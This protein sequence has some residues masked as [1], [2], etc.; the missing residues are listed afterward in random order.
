MIKLI[1]DK[2]NPLDVIALVEAKPKNSKTEWNPAW[3]KFNN[4]NI[5]SVNMNPNDCGRGILIFVIKII[6]YCIRQNPNELQEMMICDIAIDRKF[7]RLAV[8]YGSPNSP[9]LKNDCLCQSIKELCEKDVAQDY[10]VI[11]GD[12]NFPSTNW[13]DC[14]TTK[15]KESKEFKFLEAVGDAILTQHIDEPTR[16]TAGDKPS[17]L[18]INL[19]DAGLSD[20][21]TNIQPPLGQSD[22]VLI[23]VELSAH[24]K[25]SKT[26]IRHNFA[27]RDYRQMRDEVKNLSFLHSEDNV[28]KL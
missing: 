6:D 18:D 17:L 1:E 9:E 4:C 19:T 24:R 8:V 21:N 14:S 11:L 25:I 23:E 27:K 12:P 28:E 26:M 7:I 5:K 20:L 15:D 10:T 22:H 3:Y 16:I 13:D 2:K